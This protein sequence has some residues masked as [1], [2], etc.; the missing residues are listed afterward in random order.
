MDTVMVLNPMLHVT[1]YVYL[2]FMDID[3]FLFTI[4]NLF[5]RLAVISNLNLSPRL[6]RGCAL[7]PTNPSV[8]LRRQ[9]GNTLVT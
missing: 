3:T 7:Q 9:D 1:A 4:V 6:V 2:I 5:L 8:G